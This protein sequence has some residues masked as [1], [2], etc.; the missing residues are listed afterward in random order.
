MDE[1]R[2]RKVAVM[3]TPRQSTRLVMSLGPS[4][5]VYIQR[6]TVVFLLLTPSLFSPGSSISIFCSSAVALFDYSDP[7]FAEAELLQIVCAGCYWPHS[8]RPII[9]FSLYIY[10]LFTIQ[11][12][13]RYATKR[14]I[15]THTHTQRPPKNQSACVLC[16]SLSYY[17]Q[18]INRLAYYSWKSSYSGQCWPYFSHSTIQCIYIYSK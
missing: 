17:I 12:I 16:I 15:H 8:R 13:Q 9:S 18:R 4:L 11:Y 6:H 7:D 3:T 2:E 1:K 14:L 5:C 10:T